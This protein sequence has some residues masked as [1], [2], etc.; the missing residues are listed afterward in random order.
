MTV[1]LLL[2]R[3]SFI[4][5]TGRQK[6][7]S[8]LIACQNAPDE[9]FYILAT[10]QIAILLFQRTSY[11]TQSTFLSVLLTDGCPECLASSVVVT[12]KLE[13]YS[14]YVLCIVCSSEATFQH[15]ESFHNIFPQFKVKFAAHILF[16]QV[17]HFLGTPKSRVHKHTLVHNKTLPSN[18]TCLILRRE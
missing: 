2:A 16:R 7:G 6:F 1:I 11:F 9:M 17:S 12:L 13:N 8:K 5:K 15:F 18:H 3:I 4:D 10:S 14:D